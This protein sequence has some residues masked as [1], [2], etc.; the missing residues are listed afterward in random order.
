MKSF[1]KAILALLFAAS[2]AIGFAQT[3]PVVVVAPFTAV[4]DISENDAAAVTELF[5]S[6]LVMTNKFQVVEHSNLD[7]AK[8][9]LR[10]QAGDWASD[11]NKVA[12][13]GRALNAQFVI[14]GQLMRLGEQYFLSASVV[15][16]EGFEVLAASR[17]QFSRLENVMNI[18]PNMVNV[19]TERMV[20]EPK[21]PPAPSSPLIGV[22]QANSSRE[23]CSCVIEFCED[24]RLVVQRIVWYE[25]NSNWGFRQVQNPQ[26]TG[27][28]NWGFDNGELNLYIRLS[29]GKELRYNG[30]YTLG[31]GGTELQL[32]D[33]NVFGGNG[34]SV[35]KSSYERTDYFSF[36]KI[37]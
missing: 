32:H 27:E 23:N 25:E 31:M 36:H 18:L 4:G 14:R 13:I 22:W 26:A 5:S 7:A 10:F 11:N 6:Q 33:R 9:E 30:R 3:R 37:R 19:I 21:A 2:V 12:A 24:N 17:E 35:G 8:R 15:R 28:G 1:K 29:D 34:I 16:L 20:P